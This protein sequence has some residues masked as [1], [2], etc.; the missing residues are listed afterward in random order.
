MLSV[1]WKFPSSANRRPPM[2]G[3]PVDRVPVWTAFRFAPW[4]G[5]S[6]PFTKR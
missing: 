3:F 1:T 2:M 5:K 4:P 6:W